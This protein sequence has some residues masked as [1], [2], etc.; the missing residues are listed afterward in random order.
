MKKP[1]IAVTQVSKP[2]DEEEKDDKDEQLAESNH[3]S[4]STSLAL[5]S[6]G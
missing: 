1:I 5:A 3:T 6:Q 4:N 2:N